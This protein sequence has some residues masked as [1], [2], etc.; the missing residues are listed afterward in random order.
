MQ[1]ENTECECLSKTKKILN[2]Y[3]KLK[4][5][6]DLIWLLEQISSARI[7]RICISKDKLGEFIEKGKT[8]LKG[9]IDRFNYR[10]VYIAVAKYN[11]GEGKIIKIGSAGK[12]RKNNGSLEMTNQPIRRRITNAGGLFSDKN[13]E[14][15]KKLLEK[16]NIEKLIIYA[17]KI[18]EEDI[19]KRCELTPRALEAILISLYI[20]IEK[21][22]PHLH[23]DDS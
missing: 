8:A 15:I 14:E 17:I 21:E 22:L 9:I 16:E 7:C 18:E 13:R 4:E 11:N 3:C 23:K 1:I 5:E 12:I 20:K 6:E 2:K 10:G 19:K